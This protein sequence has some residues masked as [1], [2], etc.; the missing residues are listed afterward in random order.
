[1]GI[2]LVRALVLMTGCGDDG[3]LETTFNILADKGNYIFKEKGLVEDLGILE[4]VCK[5]AN[6][7]DSNDSKTVC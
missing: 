4:L 7:H 6:H 3:A 2:S 1:M 5:L